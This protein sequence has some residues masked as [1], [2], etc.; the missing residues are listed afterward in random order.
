MNPSTKPHRTAKPPREPFKWESGTIKVLE[1]MAEGMK[2]L[3][4]IFSFILK[5]SLELFKWALNLP[6]HVTRWFLSPT[7][8]L[9]LVSIFC[10]GFFAVVIWQYGDIGI[11][12]LSQIKTPAV[13]NKLGV[14][15]KPSV[16]LVSREMAWSIGILAGLIINTFQIIP[17]MGSLFTKYSKA[18][19]VLENELLEDGFKTF[20]AKARSPLGWSYSVSRRVGWSFIALEVVTSSVYA[21]QVG[22][23][24]FGIQGLLVG[25]A[26]ILLLMVFGTQ[27]VLWATSSA[28]M[29][30][31]HFAKE[32]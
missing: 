2:S 28:V 23:L 6:L 5:G 14:V 8:Q 21:Y 4:N 19:A 12:W 15:T 3:W 29:L 11:H 10:V 27:I 24:N 7:A 25:L 22:I 17:K 18:F 9:I 30:I 13:V 32:D 31:T 16:Y 1:G 20:A 26:Y